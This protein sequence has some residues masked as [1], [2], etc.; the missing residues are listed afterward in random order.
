MHLQSETSPDIEAWGW[1]TDMSNEVGTPF[2]TSRM[3]YRNEWPPY[4]IQ[5]KNANRL[6][7]RHGRLRLNLLK[8]G[9]TMP[10][11]KVR[12]PVFDFVSREEALKLLQELDWKK[13]EQ[14]LGTRLTKEIRANVVSLAF[15]I[16]TWR[17]SPPMTEVRQKIIRLKKR[18][19]KLRQ[20]LGEIGESGV[21]ESSSRYADPYIERIKKLWIP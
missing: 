15:V 13:L 18:A 16:R 21:I 17:K 8:I 11:Q 3:K 2:A 10:R 4:S 20:Y 6:L 19:Q 12:H 14:C 9:D 5:N 1:R 7:Q